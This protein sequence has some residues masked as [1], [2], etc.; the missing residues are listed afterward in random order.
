MPVPFP[1]LLHDLAGTLL[2]DFLLAA[3]FFTS[4]CYAVLG[5]R[6]GM[7]RPAVVMSACIGLALSIGLVWWEYVNGWS[8]RDLGPLAVGFGILLLAGVMY[9]AFRQVGGNWSGAG[10]AFGGSLL[11]GWAMGIEWPVD[12]GVT[13]T[14]IL[15]TL[16]VGG[17]ALLQHRHGGRAFRSVADALST[18]RHDWHDLD[19]G[20]PIA[21]QLARRTRRVRQSAEQLKTRPDRAADVMLQLKRIL[22]AEGWLTERLARLRKHAHLLRQGHIHKVVELKREI[23]NMPPPMRRKL[24]IE[25]AA[26]MDALKIDVRLERLDRAAVAAERRIKGLMQNAK[27]RVARGEHRKVVQLLEEAS[28]LQEHNAKLFKAIERTYA[29][30]TG[31]AQRAIKMHGEVNKNDKSN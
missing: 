27:E 12:A 28:R 16:L 30:L 4:V 26:Q 15:I 24:A 8:V 22:P 11:V 3:A 19:E 29:Q 13:Q 18:A 14:I 6:F 20:R 7:Q 10:L 9:Q 21:E 31:A 5:R 1:L 2:P 25:L 17:L 23:S